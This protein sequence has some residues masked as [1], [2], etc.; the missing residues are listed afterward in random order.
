MA[1]KEKKYHFIY[2]TI[3]LLNNKYYLGMHSTD[4]LN[5]G[6][7]GSGKRLKRSLN[8]YGKENHKVETLEFLDSREELKKREADIVNL[9]EIAKE[10]CMN[11]VVG[12]EGGFISEFGCKK[13]AKKMNEIVNFRKST[14]LEF[15]NKWKTAMVNKLKERHKEGKIKYNTFL[16]KKHSE[17][18]K[19]KIGLTN[20]KKQKGT[21]NSQYGT[22]WI[23]NGKNNKKIKKE[24][25]EIFILEGWNKGRI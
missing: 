22:C 23:T 25:L 13:G 18:T 14:N 15:Y 7:M 17:E 19:N 10:K 9:N 8:K 12:G 16:G 11:I 1:R 24:K 5:D 3:N 6:Y 4:N 20:S 2:K 21:L